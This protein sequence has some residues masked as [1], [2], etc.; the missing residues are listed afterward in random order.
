MKT[1]L[2]S[3]GIV[4]PDNRLKSFSVSAANQ[5]PPKRIQRLR[6]LIKSKSPHICILR[7]EGIG[8]V[9]MTTP[10]ID[11]L[12]DSFN[13]EVEITY[14]TNTQYLDGALVK[15]LKYNPNVH[16]IIDRDNLD[17][18]EYDIVINLHCPAIAH[19]KPM[20]PPI[21]R[22]DLFANHAGIKL[23][24]KLPRFFLQEEEIYQGSSYLNQI[25]YSDTK[26]IMI[27]LISSAPSRSL[28]TNHLYYALSE[29]G[30]LGYQLLIVQHYTDH[31][32]IKQ[33][34][35]LP[36]AIAIVDK[37]IREL[38]SVMV[39]CHLLICP[40]SALLH[41]AGA[42]SFPVIGL[43][44]PTDPRARINYYPTAKA[45]WGGKDL[46]GHPHWYEK[47]PCN[48]LCWNNITKDLIVN[49]SL[50]ILNTSKINHNIITE[51]I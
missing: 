35:S 36:G 40:D 41:L 28:L 51:L 23:D 30:N 48:N 22:I 16:H 20:A 32:S 21:N 17:E 45:I 46:P 37:D 43:F 31:A 7:G 26:R 11:A 27:N 33:Y 39:N 49:T 47:C 9:L 29:L 15:T 14:A 19:E 50:G 18:A 4:V 8:D 38:A 44:G 1:Y 24:K 12:V 10:I 5:H 3:Q 13:K 42:L 2:N 6:E 25:S 34:N